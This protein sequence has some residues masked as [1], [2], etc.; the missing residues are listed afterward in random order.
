MVR[1]KKRLL[2]LSRSKQ[3]WSEYPLESEIASIIDELA[4]QEDIESADKIILPGVGH[5]G[6]AMQSLTELGLLD[7]L[8]EAVL[9]KQ[10]AV[11]GICLGM[12]LMATRSEE[13]NA[14]GLKWLDAEV[15][16]FS[17]LDARQ[18]KLPHMGWNQVQIKKDSRLMK[19]VP[20]LSEFYFAHSYYLKA[21]KSSDVL[22]ETDYEIT[23]TSAIEKDNI[24]GVQFHPEKSGATGSAI[25]KN[26]IS[27]S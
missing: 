3:S 15:V 25:I 20:D 26:F 10:K 5:F 22:N 4:N 17:P 12:E 1:I 7:S 21:N 16:R 6:S 18:H 2:S 24:F 9:V 14:A 8:N 13:G 27:I 23:F 19:D 11:L